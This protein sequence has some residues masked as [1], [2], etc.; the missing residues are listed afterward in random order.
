M[1]QEMGDFASK[2]WIDLDWFGLIWINLVR[3]I[4]LIL[5][6]YGGANGI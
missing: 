2:I 1:I 3:L 5:R 4:E 6:V